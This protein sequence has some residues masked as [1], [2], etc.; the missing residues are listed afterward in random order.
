MTKRIPQLLFVVLL[1]GALT[2]CS[3]ESKQAAAQATPQKPQGLPSVTVYKSP[4][5]GCCSKWVDHMRAS[6]FEVETMDMA[7]VTPMK[8]RLGVPQDLRSCHTAYVGGYVVE[9]HVPADVVKTFLDEQ[10]EATGLTVPGMPMGS[11]G[12]EGSYS[13]SY[14]VLTFDE[15]GQRRIFAQR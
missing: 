6:G 3:S 5:C 13:E 14:N 1:A 4:T 11:P 9:G 2:A 7:D 8:E 15:Q 10:P 12:M